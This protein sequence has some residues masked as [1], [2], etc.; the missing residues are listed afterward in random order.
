MELRADLDL[1]TES[2]FL[3]LLGFSALRRL[4]FLETLDFDLERDERRNEVSL[5]S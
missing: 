2:L 4:S 3:F 5:N 1:E